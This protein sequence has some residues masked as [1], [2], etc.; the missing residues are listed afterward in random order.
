MISCRLVQIW[1]SLQ[2]DTGRSLSSWCERHLASCS[3]CRDAR[4]R[5][6]QLVR[7]LEGSAGSLRQPTPPF[8]P[9]RIIAAART[10]SEPVHTGLGVAWSRVAWALG[11]VVLVLVAG[12]APWPRNSGKPGTSPATTPVTERSADRTLNLAIRLPEPTDLLGYGAKLDEPLEQEWERFVTD[13][14]TA[15]RSLAAAFVP[16][17]AIEF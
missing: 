17:Q 2:A 16:E 3:G 15:A 7:R 9:G 6:T 8:L 1:M 11:I 14:R 10:A 13:A 5:T 4:Q 12:L